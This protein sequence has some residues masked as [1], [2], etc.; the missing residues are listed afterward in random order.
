MTENHT[1]IRAEGQLDAVQRGL[2]V[3]EGDEAAAVVSSISQ[4]YPTM[5]EDLWEACTTAERLPRWFAPVSGDLEIGGRYQIEGN[6]SGTISTCEPPRSFSATWEFGDGVSYIDV[7]VDPVDDGARL[8][9][10]HRGDMPHEFWT[11]YGAGATGAGWDLAFL[12]MWLHITTGADAPDESTDWVRT[13]EYRQFVAGSSRR[14]ADAAI[15]AGVPE[16]DARA[17]EERTTAFYT[18]QET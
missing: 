7:H 4:V 12:G 18:D 2:S 17:A 5:V 10:E 14:W 3:T 16:A 9:L 8:T 13:E 6:A 15:A 11:T 1:A